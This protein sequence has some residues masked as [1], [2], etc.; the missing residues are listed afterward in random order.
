MDAASP[1]SETLTFA[2]A[3]FTE[4]LNMRHAVMWPE[5]PRDFSRVEGDATA[6]HLGAFLDGKLVSVVSLYESEN[7]LRLRKFATLPEFQ[8][9]GIG[10]RMLQKVI[11]IAAK[12]H[13][14][15]W[16]GARL[17]AIT[18]YKRFGFREFGQRYKKGGRRFCFMERA[19]DEGQD[20]F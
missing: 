19:L 4:V 17:D 1:T 13:S 11:E 5:H 10:S 14:R 18:L 20:V 3:D 15:I 7:S 16:L 12:D 9:R 2:E 6:L 8:G